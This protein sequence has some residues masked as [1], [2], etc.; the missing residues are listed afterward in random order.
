MTA[1]SS[2]R[3]T[4][5]SSRFRRFLR[6]TLHPAVARLEMA[7][8]AVFFG[9][10]P[11]DRPTHLPHFLVI[12]GQKCG[13]TWLDSMLRFH[14]EVGLPRRRKEVHFFDGNYWRGLDWYRFHFRGAGGKVR[15]EITPAYS[16]LPV[17]RIRE[18]R[19]VNPRM[20]LVLILRHPVERAWSHVEMGLVRNRRRAISD[21]P[22]AEFLRQ[23]ESAGVLDR[24]R[25]S[26]MLRN[27]LGEFPAE[28]LH[29]EFFES[30]ASEPRPLLTRILTH[31]GADPALMPWDTMPLDQKL[32]AN[33]S[34]TI[35]A[36]YRTRLGEL[37]SDELRALRETLPR[38]E[39]FKWEA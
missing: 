7:G 15:G 29:I 36:A 31:I 10:K 6:R 8:A 16:I 21:V 24:S 30:I 39:V 2:G 11:G 32:N 9:L 28:Q 17:D 35:P 1:S 5:A 18:V 27:W 3:P 26:V 13:T 4:T 37:L 14:P 20:R 33:A 12:G 38:P 23:I 19:A 25:Y 22:E 34:R